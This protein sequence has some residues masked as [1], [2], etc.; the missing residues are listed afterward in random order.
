MDIIN[1]TMKDNMCL[2]EVNIFQTYDKDGYHLG[3]EKYDF[4]DFISN[5]L[6]RFMNDV[7]QTIR[8]YCMKVIPKYVLIDTNDL[9]SLYI[10]R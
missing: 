7:N 3:D 10:Y 9:I 6:M 8:K 2:T 4:T 5:Q 1:I